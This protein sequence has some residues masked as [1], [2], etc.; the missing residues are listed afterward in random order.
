MTEEDQFEPAPEETVLFTTD[1]SM[2]LM[3]NWNWWIAR[4]KCGC[5]VIRLPQGFAFV[6][7]KDHEQTFF[8]TIGVKP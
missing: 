6:S 8:D 5:Q 3:V 4:P 1:P 7:C 2:K